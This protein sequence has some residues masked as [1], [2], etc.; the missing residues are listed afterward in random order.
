MIDSSGRSVIVALREGFAEDLFV[1][2]PELMASY[3]RD[4]TGNYV[5]MPLSVARPRSAKELSAIVRRC[6]AL[7]VGVV[8]QGGLTGLVGAGVSDPDQPEV[9]IRFD[10]MNAVRSIDPVDYAIVVEAGCVLETAKQAAA[11]RDCLLPITFGSQGSCQIGG[12]IATNAGGF[13]VLRYGMTRDLVLGLEVVLADGKIWDGLRT[14][15]KD[16]RGYDLKQLFIGSEGTLGVITAAALKLF[17][18]P[19]QVET[20]IVGLRSVQDAMDL[21]AKAR[22]HC[23][24]LLSAFEIILSDGLA[25]ALAHRPELSSP[26]GHACPVYVLME[27]SAGGAVNLSQI[28]E[29]CL[30]EAA[31]L[32][33]D[34]TVATNRAQANKLWLLREAMV[35]AQSRGGPY[36]RTDVSVP[37]SSLPAFLDATLSELA[38]SLPDG[39]PIT[40]GH[41]GDGNI[42]LN[43]V[44]PEDWSNVQRQGLFRR[45]ED[46]IFDMVDRFGGSI[47]AEHG[48]GRSKKRAFLERVDPVTL[49]LFKNLKNVLDSNGLLSRGRIFDA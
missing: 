41:I 10:R 36:Y 12:N 3:A 38:V 23:S 39:R 30:S 32:L 45:A 43:I 13:N 16:N 44:P 28:L 22:R 47:S 5:G 49:E 9:I 33:I 17:P 48:I 37:I 8:P 14:L 6:G 4:R 7:G 21:Y 26:L 25:L 46:L 11:S 20:G 42:H 2:D 35:E 31:D 29:V 1:T 15:R 24:D 27:L 40:Y 34:G 18:Q 19:S